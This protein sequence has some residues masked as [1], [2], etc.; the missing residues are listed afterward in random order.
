[1][2]LMQHRSLQPLMGVSVRHSQPPLERG[3]VLAHR[4]FLILRPKGCPLHGLDWKSCLPAQ[5]HHIGGHPL[6]GL[7]RSPVAPQDEGHKLVPLLLRL[8]HAAFR[9]RPSVLNLRSMN[10]SLLGS[11]GVV[12]VLCIP[13][14]R[15]VSKTTFD[16]KFVPWSVNSSRNA[17]Y[18][19]TI[20]YGFGMGKHSS[21][22]KK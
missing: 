20:S 17:P 8:L 11:Y 18:R 2:F 12:L 16:L 7:W 5:H 10:P 19:A 6:A 9:H 4:G 15:H 13:N 21:H 1:M 3:H 14:S 22:F